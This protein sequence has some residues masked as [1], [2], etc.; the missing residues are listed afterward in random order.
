M[1]M[2]NLSTWPEVELVDKLHFLSNGWKHILCHLIAAVLL[3]SGLVSGVCDIPPEKLVINGV[4]F[5]LASTRFQWSLSNGIQMDLFLVGTT[6]KGEVRFM[7]ENG[8]LRTMKLAD[9]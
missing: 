5:E 1:D 7:D 8:K 4:N 6:E 2:T 3:L 9:L